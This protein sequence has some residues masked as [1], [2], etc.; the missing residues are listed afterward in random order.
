MR[1]RSIALIV[2]ITVVIILS[3]GCSSSAPSGT[4]LPVI[5]NKLST[6][7]PSEMALQL[8]E[9]P[10]GYEIKRSEITTNNTSTAQ[11]LSWKKGYYVSYQKIVTTSNDGIEISQFISI[12][13]I[14]KVSSAMSIGINDMK[15]IVGWVSTAQM[16]QLSNPNIGDSSQAFRLKNN[17]QVTGYFITFTKKDVCEQFFISGS[18]TDYEILKDVAVKAA[19]KIK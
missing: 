10:Q 5:G 16:E 19:A 14:D 15:A 7:E 4:S 6:I 1:K 13:P 12:Y 17:D 18:T 2:L 3:A 9:L 11:N 8:S